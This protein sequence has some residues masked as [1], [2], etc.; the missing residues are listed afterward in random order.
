M[1]FAPELSGFWSAQI[2]F[3]TR[4]Q[5]QLALC[6]V[7]TLQ[8]DLCTSL[9]AMTRQYNSRLGGAPMC[10]STQPR[11]APP[12]GIVC[13]QRRP[14]AVGRARFSTSDCVRPAGRH[15]RHASTS[16]TL[17][18]CICMYLEAHT[19]NIVTDLSCIYVQKDT[20][21]TP[22]RPDASWGRFRDQG[23][24]QPAG[25]PQHGPS[26]S[27]GALCSDCVSA[28]LR[29]CFC[30]ACQYVP[31]KSGSSAKLVP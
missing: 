6:S 17:H 28:M 14:R 30:A 18:V 11:A 27:V 13:A 1:S 26:A 2:G 9:H 7:Q 15:C 5:R 31:P 21:K 8:G 16:G 22:S 20:S 24:H 23:A 4:P 29:P 12:Q 3:S 25:A 10:R 19:D